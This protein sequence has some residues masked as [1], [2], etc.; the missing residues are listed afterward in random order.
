VVDLRKYEPIATAPRDETLVWVY[1]ELVGEVLARHIGDS[2]WRGSGR[3]ILP[4]HWRHATLEEVT[5]FEWESTAR[6]IE[7]WLN[8]DNHLAGNSQSALGDVDQLSLGP[9]T[10]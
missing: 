1:S 6:I 7:T 10:G 9:V 8:R 5:T 2:A 4:T 3:L